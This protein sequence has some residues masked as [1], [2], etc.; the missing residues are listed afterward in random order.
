M[1]IDYDGGVHLVGAQRRR[2]R[3]RE[4]TFR[5]AGLE[6]MTVLGSDQDEELLA[7]RMHES[8]ARA[9]FAAP[10]ERDW[11]TDPPRWWIPTGTVEQRRNL[12]EHER[13]RLLRYRRTA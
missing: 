7:R 5:R 2:D 12:A 4:E 10:L 3:D 1:I 9:R 11:T 13:A 6:Y 8:R